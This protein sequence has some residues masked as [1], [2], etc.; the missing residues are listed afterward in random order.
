MTIY[1]TSGV[2]RYVTKR[3][4]YNPTSIMQGYTYPSKIN[5]ATNTNILLNSIKRK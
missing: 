3:T 1:H 2:R 5:V 4:L